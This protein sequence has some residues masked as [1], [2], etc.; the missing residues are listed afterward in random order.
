MF[1]DV[2]CITARPDGKIKI[3]TGLMSVGQGHE[4][5]V[6]KLASDVLEVIERIIYE[7]GDT[8]LLPE[9]RGN[10]G[11]SATVVGVSAVKIA[12]SKFLSEASLIV[13]SVV[14]CPVDCDVC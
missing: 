2:A 4:T 1:K 3:D 8:D 7:Q 13:S 14:G 6:S 5:A 11:S 10:G 9:G 12:L